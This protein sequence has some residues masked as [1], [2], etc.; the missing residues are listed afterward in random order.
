[1]VIPDVVESEVTHQRLLRSMDTLDDRSDE[2]NDMM[3][4]LL[5]RLI[6]QDLSV[7]FD[8]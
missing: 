6:D 1:V 4:D 8:V 2:V 3:S 7:V 5:M